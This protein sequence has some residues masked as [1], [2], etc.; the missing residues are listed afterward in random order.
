M[1]TLFSLSTLGKQSRGSARYGRS[2]GRRVKGVSA[3][4][5]QDWLLSG[6]V[7]KKMENT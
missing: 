2:A 5:N 7:R 4:W 6:L 3:W 1:G